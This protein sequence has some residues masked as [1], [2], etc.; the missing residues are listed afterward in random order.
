MEKAAIVLDALNLIVGPG[1]LDINNHS[2]TSLL[3][4]PKMESR[5]K[6]GITTEMMG[7]AVVLLRQ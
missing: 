4:D 2:D 6:Q 1:F 3:V 5:T 7:I